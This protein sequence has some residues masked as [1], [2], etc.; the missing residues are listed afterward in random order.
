MKSGQ[1]VH[2]NR[3]GTA[4][5]PHRRNG[6]NWP[7]VVHTTTGQVAPSPVFLLSTGHVRFQIFH[8][9][10]S[11]AK[12]PFDCPSSMYCRPS[13]YSCQGPLRNLRQHDRSSLFTPLFNLSICNVEFPSHEMNT[14]SP[15]PPR[16]LS[17][18]YGYEAGWRD[19]LLIYLCPLLHYGPFLLMD[20]VLLSRL[21]CM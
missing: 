7:C 21:Y 18:S 4:S 10:P 17:C 9:A 8:W 2:W 19:L 14:V 20:H 5:R 3:E 15:P 1:P 6:T 11:S 16:V 12:S 13:Y